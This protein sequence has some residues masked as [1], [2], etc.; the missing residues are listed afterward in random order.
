VFELVVRLLAISKCW[1]DAMWLL[2]F[3]AAPVDQRRRVGYCLAID[4]LGS[5]A[6]DLWDL[7]RDCV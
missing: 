7:G 3:P 2:P 1:L 6:D 5:R 4:G